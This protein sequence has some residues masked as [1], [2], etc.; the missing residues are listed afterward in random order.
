[1]DIKNYNRSVVR[2]RSIISHKYM[3]RKLDHAA[4][5]CYD[6]VYALKCIDITVYCPQL[7]NVKC[8]ITGI[9]PFHRICYNGHT[10]LITFMLGK[11]A[12]PSIATVTG[13]NALCMAVYYF[14]NNPLQDDFSCLE[15][16]HE[17]GCRFGAKNKW[18]TSLLKMAVTNKNTKLFQWL[19]LHQK[20]PLYNI[21]RSYST[22]PH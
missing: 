1:M 14:L 12:D 5:Q 21:S 22:P 7:L 16:L 17:T 2:Q 6:K 11:G 19:I 13:E 9:T 10:C 20:A 4:N 18:Y 3:F 8:P 15:L